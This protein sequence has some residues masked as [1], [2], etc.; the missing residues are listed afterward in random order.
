MY[1]APPAARCNPGFCCSRQP[2]WSRQKTVGLDGQESA[3]SSRNLI[4]GLLNLTRGH[5][6]AFAC[7]RLM[8]TNFEASV[9][10]CCLAKGG[11]T[12]VGAA[13]RSETAA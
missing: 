7:L 9:L 2:G 11:L 6:S 3:T 8:L 5:R 13:G 12:C 1:P 4:T 10:L